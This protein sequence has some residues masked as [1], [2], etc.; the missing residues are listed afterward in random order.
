MISVDGVAKYYGHKTVLH[1][2]TFDLKEG[3]ILCLLGP[4]GSG[5]STLLKIV[6]GVIPASEG[7]VCLGSKLLARNDGW[8]KEIVMVWQSM[9]LF[10]HYSVGG[11]VGFGLAVRSVRRRERSAKVA[12][13]LELV[14]LPNFE[15]RRVGTLS[16]G[17][18]QRVALARAI[19]LEPRVLLLDEPFGSLDAH[20]RVSLVNKLREIHKALG[21]SILMVT[22]DQAEAITIANRIAVLNEGKLQQI[23][24]CNTVYEQPHNGFVARFLGSGNVVQARLL[25]VSDRIARVQIG[26]HQ[27][28]AMIPKW[29]SVEAISRS[30]RVAHVLTPDQVCIGASKEHRISGTVAAVSRWGS[31]SSVEI[32]SDSFGSFK[33][34]TEAIQGSL[35]TS[36]VSLSWDACNAYIVP[37]S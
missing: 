27:Y 35:A 37:D 24:E 2:T 3:E 32:I 9:A 12:K 17:E 21:L 31:F 20:L 6:A 4:S 15:N 34:R 5:K 18:M 22:H 30:S 33:L 13:A 10:P 19:I 25:D 26:D 8:S 36:G 23:G 16:G 1:P 14:G 7:T 29:I 11:N 28:R